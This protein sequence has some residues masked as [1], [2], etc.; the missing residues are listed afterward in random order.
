[1]SILLGV[2]IDHVAT[3]RQVRGGVEPSLLDAALLCEKC[4]VNAVTVHLREDRRHIQDK[5]VYDIKKNLKIQLNLEMSLAS[6]VID[7]ALDV[8]PA[9][10]TIVPEKREELTTEGGLDVKGNLDALKKVTAALKEKG[11]QVSY[12]IEPDFE[13]VK[14]SREAGADFIEFHTGSYA[15]QTASDRIE[16]E[17]MRLYRSAE[18]ASSIGL[19]VNAGHG[20][21]YENVVPVLKMKALHE[22]NIGHSIVSRAL[23]TGLEK[24]I[25]DMNVLLAKGI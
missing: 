8:V 25:T 1:M 14:L 3:L 18:L 4:A 20:L 7:L 19:G 22:L 2:N 5:D 16:H 24:A 21:N 13:A 10:A 23:F 11:I 9:M 17:L 12:F 6:D 15:N